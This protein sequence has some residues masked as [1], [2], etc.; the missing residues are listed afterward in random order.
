MKKLNRFLSICLTLFCVISSCVVFSGCKEKAV[1]TSEKFIDVAYGDHS[2]QTL[3]LY[4][5]KEKTGTVGL[6]LMIHG[7][8]WVAG[9]KS[10]YAKELAYWCE[11]YGY[12]V[13]S[14]NYRY[15]SD[16]FNCYDI[17]QDIGAGLEKIK[18]LAN[19]K[20]IDIEKAML[21]GSSAGGHLSLLYAYKYA[22]SSAI[23]PVAV[24]NYSGPTDITDS[25][26]YSMEESVLDY[27][28]LFSLLCGT[29]ITLENRNTTEIQDIML[30]VSP[31]NHINGKTVPTLI[32]HGDKDNIVPY[33]NATTLK[34]RL[35][36]YGVKNDFVSYKNAGHSLDNK[37][38][39]KTARKLFKQYANDYLN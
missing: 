28:N 12:A 26:Y 37:K 27:L 38:A 23:K 34:N 32:C 29:T 13:A 15:I 5:P 10:G 4:L 30:D 3:N 2:R 9:D 1:Y 33:S 35:D 7:G 21:T 18:T 31:I 19:E 6:I 8:A 11:T 39:R 14:I 20:N 22:E 36:F 16:Q 17:M 24:A 25:G